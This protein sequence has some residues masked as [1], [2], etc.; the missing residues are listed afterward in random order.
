MSDGELFVSGSDD[1]LEGIDPQSNHPAYQKGYSIGQEW[2]NAPR[3]EPTLEDA[4][5]YFND[6]DN[7]AYHLEVWAE[8]SDDMHLVA[9]GTLE[10]CYRTLS[11]CG[12]KGGYT[13]Y[14]V[15]DGVDLNGGFDNGRRDDGKRFE[16]LA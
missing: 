1:G 15:V 4:E 12:G 10:D 6:P 13:I 5:D 9:S 7:I 14:C 3:Y 8:D 16:D 2:A 11:K